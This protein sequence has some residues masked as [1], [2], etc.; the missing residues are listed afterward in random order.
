M[1]FDPI[2]R[3]SH[4]EVHNGQ[5]DLKNDCL[6]KT[7]RYRLNFLI[8]FEK[9]LLKLIIKMQCF[10]F[11]MPASSGHNFDLLGPELAMYLYM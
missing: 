2:I 1:C 5:L 7:N 3:N 4:K 6:N 11:V 8:N 9:S 10:I